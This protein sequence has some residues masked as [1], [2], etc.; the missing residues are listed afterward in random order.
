ME[1]LQIKNLSFAYPSSDRKALDGVNLTVNKGDFVLVAGLSG[2]G[3]T[4]L[5]R[6]IKNEIAPFGEK[7]GEILING[8]A[9]D[10]TCFSKIGY[11]GQDPDGQIVT[12]KVWHELAFGLENEGLERE[13][14]RS[15]VGE[16]AGFFGINH[17]YEKNTDE[18]SG[19][20]K[21]LLNLA[22]VTVMRP[23]LLLLDEPTSQLDPISAA[24]FIYAVEKINRETGTTVIMC[25][26]RLGNVFPVAD[27]ALILKNGRVVCFDSPRAV[28]EKMKDDPVF[29]GFPSA[30]R[31]WKGLD[32]KGECPITVREGKNFLSSYKPKETIFKT[33]TEPEKRNIAINISGVCFKYE[34]DLPDAVKNLDLTVYKGEIFG[35]IGANGS[36]KSTMLDIIAGVKS[37]YKGV[38]EISGKNIKKYKNSELYNGNISLLP[39]NVRTLFLRNTV[40]EDFKDYLS[41]LG[42]K[43]DKAAEKIGNTAKQFEITDLLNIHPYDLSGGEAQKC[44]IAKLSLN[45]PEILLFDEPTKGIDAFYKNKLIGLIKEMKKQGK[46]VVFVTHDIEFAAALSDRVGM[47]FNGG[48]LSCGTP[49]AIFS[50]NNYYTTDAARISKEIISGAVLCEEVISA[51]KG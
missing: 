35:I 25:E 2:C 49:G 46:T 5:L 24:N 21:Q 15:R 50:N 11:V 20:Q 48:L 34:K 40:E 23:E 31:I 29:E 44:A 10:N 8:E 39:Q 36:G 3:K 6:L 30:S 17:W 47:I 32:G 27:K 51:C 12:D 7:S 42:F 22:A 33:Q 28:C 9:S 4:T 14:I 38:C 16:T 18:L 37:A 1:H 19:G 43:N 13:I 26:H 45:N 41:L